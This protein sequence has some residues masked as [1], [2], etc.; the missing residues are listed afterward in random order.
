MFLYE[1]EIEFEGHV[2]NLMAGETQST[3]YLKINPRGEVPSMQFGEEIINGSDE[4]LEYL[5]NNKLG[6]RSLFPTDQDQLSKH[7]QLWDKLSP[8]SIDV[9][10]FGTAFFPEIRTV[11][12]FPIKWPMIEF[13]KHQVLNR[14]EGLRKKAAENAGTTAENVL[15]AKAEEHDK[16]IYLFTK[17]DEH[18]RIHQEVKDVLDEVEKELALHED[19]EWL[20]RDSF[21]AADCLLAILINRLD[22][23]GYVDY[24]TADT[25]PMLA[26]WWNRVKDRKSLSM[27]MEIQPNIPLY[28]LKSKP[29]IV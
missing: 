18:K 3:W 27:L 28:M 13:M 7:R 26:A 9:I 25:R 29:G 5:E 11:K 16:R 23:L 24:M 17:E 4:I 6:K 21:L 2:V 8:I 22:F 12:K 19:V 20:I 10:T 14:S 1:K 15:L